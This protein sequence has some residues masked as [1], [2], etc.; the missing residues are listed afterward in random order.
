MLKL[1]PI[2]LGFLILFIFSGGAEAWAQA[3]PGLGLPAQ[4]GPGK[5][6]GLLREQG[7]G[8]P[9]GYA[10][11]IFFPLRD[12]TQI[13]G[14]AMTAENGS[15]LVEG[16]P[17]GQY[18][19]KVSLVG[20]AT[21]RLPA[22][23][24]TAQ[25]PEINLGTISFAVSSTR[26]NEVQ[27]QGERAAVSYGLDRKVIHVA[28]DLTSI[29]GTA[30]DVM[31]NVPSVTVDADGGISLRGSSNLRILID[32]RPTG[33]VA[34][35]QAQ[36]LEQIPASSIESVEIIT[37]PSSKFDAEG[38]GGIINI[39]LKKEK[40]QGYNGLASLNVG[41]NNRYNA[42]LSGN[43]RYRKWNF[44]GGYDFRQDNRDGFGRQQRYTALA[45]KISYLYQQEEETRRY[46]NN[47]FKLGVDFTLA[48]RQTLSASWQYRDRNSKESELADNQLRDAEQTLTQHF[49]RHNR[50]KDISANTDYTLAYRRTFAKKQRELT[51][52]VVYSVAD[53]TEAQHF[54][55]QY[56][57]SDDEL[58][59]VIQRSDRPEKNNQL[60]AQ[61]DYTDP[62]GEDGRFDAG[63]KSII[64]RRDDAYAFEDFEQDTW[65][66]NT[67][68]SNRFIF[69]QQVHSLY[70]TYGNKWGKTSY[71]IGGRL[72]QTRS[73][74]EQKAKGQ[75]APDTSYLNFFPSMFLTRE[76]NK[77]NQ[78]QLSYSRR[79]NRPGPWNLNPFRDQSDPLNP[80]EGNPHLRPEFANAFEFSQI[81]YGK[82]GASLNTT[83][84]FRQ[85]NDVIQR[86]R[87][88]LSEDTILSTSIN[89]AS[90]QAY[91][92]ELVA[93]H[94]LY[95]IWKL[96]GNFS[97]FRN[98]L[99]G[100]NAGTNLNNSNFSY[101]A[102]I[103]SGITFWKG[104]ALQVSA[105]YRSPMV[106]AQGAMEAMYFTE[107]ALKKDIM[108]K[109]G[110]LTF[111][112]NDIFNTQEFTITQTGEDFNATN[113]RKRQSRMAFIGFAYR[114]GNLTNLGDKPRSRK[115]Q[116]NGAE[117]GEGEID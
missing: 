42:S 110:T 107:L 52:D 92:L 20:F 36:I 102:R 21:K 25:R 6:R 28:K 100:S 104:L 101:T 95:R 64:T 50:E 41:N 58:A 39:I 68:V 13:A 29:A 103:N 108:K 27:V 31:K 112:L 115:D 26:L 117:E 33:M 35:D 44:F 85:T 88:P 78:F 55:Q 40:N 76:I 81:H 60:T 30:T 79:I 62:I 66:Y 91:G 47:A 87:I 96:T 45:G 82:N 94:T 59:P 67:R 56:L 90:R 5:V 34:N 46:A 48:P 109:K 12:T 16:L 11:V 9:V 24:I 73:L 65:V 99:T 22:V 93:S 49:T 32:G 98:V 69:N 37:N 84:F 3:G 106:F 70:A 4:S 72:E 1:S 114:F 71:Q 57:V 18:L 38:E 116:Q 75:I 105:N 8:R 14:G 63:Y 23:S 2:P 10:N 113:Y 19:V 7:Q 77:N 74:G 111:R 51:A 61:V 53:G 17:L 86:Y 80:N 43:Y 83:L 54:F 15:F 89:L 97:A